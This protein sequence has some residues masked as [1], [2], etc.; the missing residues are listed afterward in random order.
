[1]NAI[2]LHLRVKQKLETMGCYQLRRFHNQSLAVSKPC[3]NVNCSRKPPA[4][5]THDV[6]KFCPAEGHLTMAKNTPKI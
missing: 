5:Q 6:R 1:M 4:V 3:C 2:N